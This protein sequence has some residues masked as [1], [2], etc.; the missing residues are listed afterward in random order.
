[1]KKSC[2]NCHSE[3]PFYFH[4]RD[5]NRKVSHEV[6]SHYKCSKCKLVFISPVPDNLTDYYPETYYCIPDSDD[7]LDVAS[8]PER[9]KI[10][11]V[12]QFIFSGR[13]LEIGPSYG[14]F[15]Y[16][17]KKAGFEVDVIEMNK[18]CC[19]FLERIVGVN[20]INSNDPV[21]VLQQ[22][23]PYDVVALWHVIEHLSDPWKILDAIYDKLNPGGI[24][25]IAAPNPDSFQFKIMQSYWPHVDSPR[26]L[27]LIP[28]KLIVEKF[29]SKGM[30]KEL[31]TTTDMGSIGWNRFGW[32]FFFTNL[33]SN[34]YFKRML[35]LIGR[36][37]CFLL[38]PIEKTK[39]RGSAY[40]IVFRKKV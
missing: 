12:Q 10:E 20:T 16:L 38:S 26:H 4:S 32:E 25:I 3:S 39:Y 14:S 11:I 24:V 36:L 37:V 31:V 27:M 35:R 6:F 1:M 22:G 19:Q 29:E 23:D 13:L 7:Q 40:T 8:V 18:K 28:I 9:Y 5:Y 2:P 17:A 21:L 15:T 34:A 30:Q 33:S